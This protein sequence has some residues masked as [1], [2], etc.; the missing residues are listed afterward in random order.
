[1]LRS[2]GHSPRLRPSPGFALLCLML[3]LLWLAGGASVGTVI[4][5]VIVRAAS[6]VLM[7]AAT[8]LGVRPDLQ[9][10]KPVWV[11]LGATIG[12]V[13]LQLLPLP[14]ALWRSLP[15]RA[16]EPA[17]PSASGRRRRDARGTIAV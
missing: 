14:P 2:L 1:M 15:G 3:T 13:L 17:G 11:I 16:N 4:G 5:Q 7:I 8:V 10:A 12:L 9:A 6:I